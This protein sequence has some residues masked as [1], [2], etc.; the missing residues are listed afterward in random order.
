MGDG[1]KAKTGG[2]DSVRGMDNERERGRL[3]TRSAERLESGF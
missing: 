1:G 2:A 3:A